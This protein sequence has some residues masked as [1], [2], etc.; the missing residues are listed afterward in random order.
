MDLTEAEDIKQQWQEYTEELYK[1]ELHNPDNHNGVIIHLEPDILECKVMWAL[2]NITVNKASGGD[3]IPVELFQILKDDAVKVLHSICQQV[4]KTQQWPQD[5]K[6][7]VFTS[8]PREGNAK[9]C[10]NYRTIALISHTSRVMLKILQARLQQ[11]VNCELSDVQARC[12]KD[13]G[14]R[15]QIANIRQIIRKAREFQKSIYFCFIDYAKAF[16]CVDHNKL[17]K[18][19]KE[20]GIPNHLTCLLR[21]LYAGQEATVRTEHGTTDWFQQDKEY[22]QAIYCCSDYLSYMQSTP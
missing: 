8:I 7:S 15:D 22:V 12:R 3:G 20:M 5:W 19:L 6:R 18:I 9:E 21:N 4:W 2:G 14:T 17:W 10:S 13:R 16:D 11:Y 1:K